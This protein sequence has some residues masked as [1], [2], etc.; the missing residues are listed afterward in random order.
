MHSYLPTYLPNYLPAVK[1]NSELATKFHKLRPK[2]G[3]PPPPPPFVFF[4]RAP[5][6]LS[7]PLIHH[8]NFLLARPMHDIRTSHGFILEN[9]NHAI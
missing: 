6:P 9:L 8:F 2:L 3:S 4:F 5:S 7:D 1:S